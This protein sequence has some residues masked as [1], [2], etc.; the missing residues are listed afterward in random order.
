MP[1]PEVPKLKAETPSASETVQLFNQ[2]D[3][4]LVLLTQQGQPILFNQP[5]VDY[6]PDAEATPSFYQHILFLTQK[7]QHEKFSLQSWIQDFSRSGKQTLLSEQVWLKASYSEY[8]IPVKLEICNITLD[9]QARLLLTILDQTLIRQFYAHTKLIEEHFAGQF[10]TDSKGFITEPNPAFCEYT[11]LSKIALQ[12]L[13]YLSWLK[14]QVSFQVPFDQVMSSLLHTHHWTGS[15]QIFNDEKATFKAIL[16]LTMLTDPKDNIEHFIGILQ[17]LTAI[18]AAEE[19]ISKLSYFDSLTGL[20]NRTK[21]KILLSETDNTED[22]DSVCHSLIMIGLEGLSMI[23]DTYGAQVG[24]ELLILV[25][26]KIKEQLPKHSILARLESSQ[27][28]VLFNTEYDDSELALTEVSQLAIRLLKTIKGKYKLSDYSLHIG[29][30]LGVCM[31]PII[32]ELNESSEEKKHTENSAEKFI[33]YANMA[34]AEA[35]KETREHFYIFEQALVDKAH[36][37]LELI[38]ALNHSEMDNEFQIYFQG[39]VDAEGNMVSAETL[40]R[41]FHPTLGLIPPSKFI[42]VAEKGRQIIKIGLWVLHKAFLQAKAWQAIKPNFRI[43]INISPIQFHEQSFIEII[44]GLI[45]FTQAD[46]NHLTLELT[47]G[48]LIKN[49]QLALQ[50]IQHLVSLGFEVSIDDFGTGYSSL[51]YLQK[52]PIHELKIDRSFV[53]HLQDN[54]DDDAIVNSIIQLAHSKNLKLVA[55]GVESQ[56]QANYLIKKS[57]HI[58]LQGY[59]F[60]R[61]MPADEFEKQFIQLSK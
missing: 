60:C 19:K 28:A 23:N 54:P 38:E 10:I 4:A 21:L 43:A 33:S 16:S 42:P 52:L 12:K 13:N 26:D 24:D 37:Q 56:Q 50:K 30:S 22:Y 40:I 2:M 34:L 7:R 15:V 47:E 6:F 35:R 29:A 44:I 31:L 32:V 11:K 1:L 61:P 20:A 58:I 27:F 49:A 18:K 41:W 25:A 46:A 55:E 39:Q 36:S 45:K 53:E 9:G 57:P 3:K 48:V 59:H 8:A 14:K 51:S 5:F 17:D